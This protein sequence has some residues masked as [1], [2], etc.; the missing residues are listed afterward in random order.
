[1]GGAGM[2]L[3][4]AVVARQTSVAPGVRVACPQLV[5][6]ELA[7][8]TDCVSR[9]WLS[10]GP[11]VDRL[12]QAFA[13]AIA[14][15]GGTHAVAVS[16]GTVALHLAL[17]AAGV[18]PGDEVIVPALTY[19]ATANAVRYC[20]ATPVFADV[21]P[22]TWCL[23]VVEAAGKVTRRTKAILP[24]HLY[25]GMPDMDDLM[26]LARDA[27]LA[28]VEDAAEA[29]GSHHSGRHAGTIGLAGTFSFF[30]NKTLTCGEG[31]MVVVADAALADRVRRL[32]RQGVAPA[33]TAWHWYAHDSVGFN[34]RLTD[35][36]AAVALAQVESRD[37]HLRRRDEVAAFYAGQ[38]W[39][40]GT[41]PHGTGPHVTR[42]PWMCVVLVPPQCDREVVA[43]GMAAVGVET[44]PAF[45]LVPWLPMYRA[46]AM[47]S[48]P[49]AA[50]VSNRGLCLPTHG[51]LTGEDMARVVAAFRD[52]TEVGR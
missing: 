36:Q 20:G 23:S 51:G 22:E 33:A 31:G 19:V 6:N 12:E 30:G 49:V 32:S 1:M 35:L 15:G 18:G 46:G 42:S 40:A 48:W 8:V 5:G 27:K 17:L 45:L 39:P 41:V 24:V 44:R 9:G 14:P 21:H 34:Y 2:S 13:A 3:K 43:A 29:F 16:N 10:S 50:E 38:D 4:D 52:A 11:Y 47:A 26:D 28:V 7:Y 37:W 25:G